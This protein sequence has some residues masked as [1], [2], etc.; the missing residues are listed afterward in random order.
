MTSVSVPV[1]FR[2][3]MSTCADDLS[4]TPAQAAGSEWRPRR[5]E[6]GPRALPACTS[7]RPETV[8]E[9][10]GGVGWLE[11]V[12]GW[13]N[14]VW[15]CFGE[16]RSPAQVRVGDRWFA[17]RSSPR[18]C[19]AQ[20][21]HARLINRTRPTPSM[22]RVEQ[23]SLQVFCKRFCGSLPW[24]RRSGSGES[25]FDPRRGNLQG[26]ARHCRRPLFDCPLGL[27]PR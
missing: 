5:D 27:A 22:K 24:G 23:N 4:H 1:T 2:R 25:W 21:A 13:E 6:T 3:H 11:S 14:G 26:A 9:Q 7:D 18:S 8:A 15:R 17:C 19:F 10:G 16:H 12:E 20:E